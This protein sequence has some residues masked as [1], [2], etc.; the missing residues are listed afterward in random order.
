M[1]FVTQ[2]YPNTALGSRLVFIGG[3]GGI[4]DQSNHLFD[5]V[6][7]RGDIWTTEDGRNWTMIASSAEV[8]EVAWMGLSVWEP[9]STRSNSPRMWLVGG[10]YIGDNGNRRV[11]QMRASVSVYWSQTGEKWT[12]V[13][14]VSGGG[15]STLRRYSSSEWTRTT[16]DGT[17]YFLGLWGLT[18]EVFTVDGI[19]RLYMLGG[20]QDGGGTYSGVVYQGRQ[21]LLCDIEGVTCS[22]KSVVFFFLFHFIL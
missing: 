3:Y 14:F 4:T 11:T 9:D 19:E 10:G 12:Q 7:S 17:L 21:G 22:G 16:I 13:N 18:T 15:K 5:G 20:D 2:K 6:R 8:G 1:G